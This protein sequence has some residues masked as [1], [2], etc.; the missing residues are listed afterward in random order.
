MGYKIM[1]IA[2]LLLSCN[3]SKKVNKKIEERDK[4]V[5]TSCFTN[6]ELA[7]EYDAIQVAYNDSAAYYGMINDPW[8]STRMI[9][10]VYRYAA[11]SIEHMKR[12]VYC[13]EEWGNGYKDSIMRKAFY[14]GESLEELRRQNNLLKWNLKIK[15]IDKNEDGNN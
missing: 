3:V 10:S 15:K 1:L 9:D 5:R 11:L 2:L 6:F 12:F 4:V 13:T 14:Y 7:I 8:N